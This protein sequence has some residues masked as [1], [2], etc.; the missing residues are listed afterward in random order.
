MNMLT[1][2]S[3]VV[4]QEAQI[5]LAYPL[6]IETVKFIRIVE[7]VT[8]SKS[9]RTSK[10]VKID[11]VVNLTNIFRVIKSTK[12]FRSQKFSGMPAMP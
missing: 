1:M 6:A 5:F 7:S 3:C 9:F 11:D 8:V 10:S 12:T 2:S 4:H